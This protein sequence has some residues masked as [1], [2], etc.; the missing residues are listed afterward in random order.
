M[1]YE[2]VIGVMPA[3]RAPCA[4]IIS[5]AFEYVEQLRTLWGARPADALSRKVAA[6]CRLV[7]IRNG[8]LNQALAA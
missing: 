8:P 3:R 6:V 4:A 2:P 1:V 7:G 5:R